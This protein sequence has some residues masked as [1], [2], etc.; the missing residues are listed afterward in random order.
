MAL[1]PSNREGRLWDRRARLGRNRES[2]LGPNLLIEAL[3]EK[4]SEIILAL[5][6]A[7]RAELLVAIRFSGGVWR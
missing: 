5:I 1:W 2:M 4:V 7:E 3:G 6:K